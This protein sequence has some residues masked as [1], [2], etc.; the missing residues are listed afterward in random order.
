MS[1]TS[2][3]SSSNK[4]RFT[5]LSTG[6]DTEAI[7]NASL[8]KDKE[9]IDNLKRKQIIAEWKQ[10]KYRTMI[11][12]MQTFQNTF[13]SNTNM[14]SNMT[15]PALYK[16]YT[17][18]VTTP[19]GTDS[20]LFSVSGNADSY[21]GSYD[22]K[23]KQRASAGSVK[24]EKL[25]QNV[26]YNKDKLKDEQSFTITLD[27]ETRSI[28]LPTQADAEADTLEKRFENTLNSVFEVDD[29]EVETT[30]AADGTSSTTIKR[31]SEVW[32]L[33]GDFK[34][35][36]VYELE[37]NGVKKKVEVLPAPAAGSLDTEEKRLEYALNT[38]FGFTKSD[39]FSIE[40][41]QITV[42]G[43]HSDIVINLS[44]DIKYSSSELEKLS[45]KESEKTNKFT[46]KFNGKESTFNI[47]SKVSIENMYAQTLNEAFGVSGNDG[48]SVS[49]TTNEETK[50]TTTTISRNGITYK[51]IDGSIKQGDSIELEVEGVKKTVAVKA[52][53]KTVAERLEYA[54]NRTFG[55]SGTGDNKFEVKNGKI[56]PPTGSN[57]ILVSTPKDIFETPITNATNE[58]RISKSSSLDS[59]EEIAKKI[60]LEKNSDGVWSLTIKNK[61]NT[62]KTFEF[63]GSDTLSTVM[64][65]VNSSDIG[66][67]MS[68]DEV[69]DSV[70]FVSKY[71]GADSAPEITK[72]DKTKVESKYTVDSGK[73]SQIV[74][75]G[76]TVTK[77]DNNIVLNGISI[78]ILREPTVDETEQ[79]QTAT[80]TLNTDKIFENVKKMIDQ[81]NEL[82]TTIN[83]EIN[84]KYDKKD[85]TY[86]PLLDDE[87][88]GMSE[89]E[90]K[91]WE[92]RAKQ[93]LLKNDS[94]LESFAS[95]LRTAIYSSTEGITGGIYD[96][97]ITTSKTTSLAGVLEVDEEELR[98]A[99]EKDPDK[100]MDIFTKD[101]SV[102]YSRD[103]TASEAEKRFKECGVMQRISDIFNKYVTTYRDKNGKKGL[104]LEKAGIT[105]DT[106]ATDNILTNEINDYKDKIDRL[107]DLYYD[108]EDRLY[109]KYAALET[110]MSKLNSQQ[111]S[112]A[113]M[114]GTS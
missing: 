67:S 59:M 28:T 85:R 8:M 66:V 77:S 103:L 17:G 10:E 18:K 24:T 68:Y 48:F 92:E 9:K 104:L 34:A 70:A 60:G 63:K 54:L 98:K 23:I 38:A 78:N 73:D 32:N 50:K 51:T 82:I 83:V 44:G 43:E 5:G 91:K 87:K 41:G 65:T 22:I 90:I 25:S 52:E 26:S 102:A 99:I 31:G 95:E 74:F 4:I 11:E 47:P 72:R 3:S 101:S 108:K 53:P 20:T 100:V 111:S 96:L 114:L 61:E 30:T 71:T 81:Y 16:Q 105:S 37:V 58:A 84:Q 29:F 75:N 19:A 112:L 113:S 42:G 56:T 69:T 86:Q 62:Y 94:L 21:P 88:E 89:D 110:A 46:V 49:V 7:V 45:G 6:L 13:M 107:Q 27:G 93:K 40:D 12:K 80:L 15:R 57:F 64:K 33:T 2:R 14:S 39:G 79:T 76:K 55:I 109:K 106:T 1:S 36:N 97:G 35:G